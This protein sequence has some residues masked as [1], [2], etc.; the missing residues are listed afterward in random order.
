MAIQVGMTGRAWCDRA[1]VWGR[2]GL[3]ISLPSRLSTLLAG[4]VHEPILTSLSGWPGSSSGVHRS[5]PLRPQVTPG[6]TA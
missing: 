5:F 3:S 4:L 6:N 2:E 1:A